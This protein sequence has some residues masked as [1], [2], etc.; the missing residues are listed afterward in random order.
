MRRCVGAACLLAIFAGT[1][2]L[3]DE[4]PPRQRMESPADESKEQARIVAYLK[5]ESDKILK[6]S[7]QLKSEAAR[8]HSEA[9][10]LSAEASNLQ[11]NTD[12]ASGIRLD[13]RG[14]V[15]KDAASQ[16]ATAD[17]VRLRSTKLDDEANKL[18]RLAAAID[19]QAQKDLLDRMR[20]C[21]ALGS[22]IG[23]R[24]EVIRIAREMGTDYTP[25]PLEQ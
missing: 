21:C 8:L 6:A 4:R 15:P 19:P 23:V 22:L 10:H 24:T 11:A 16:S 12:H 9:D 13:R 3:A 25:D 20:A 5:A 17:A 18:A 1:P 14:Y 2:T 7:T